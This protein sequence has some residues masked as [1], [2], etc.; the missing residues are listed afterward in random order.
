MKKVKIGWLA[1]LFF[2][3]FLEKTTGQFFGDTNIADTAPI[4]LCNCTVGST[5][6]NQGFGGSSLAVAPNG[7]TYSTIDSD[8][9]YHDFATGQNVFV[10]TMPAE[11]VGLVYGADGL[12]YATISTA[13]PGVPDQL[14][15]INPATG[16]VTIL[17]N[18]PLPWSMVGDIFFYGGQLYGW[19]YDFPNGAV[20]FLVEINVTNPLASTIV[21]STT[22]WGALIAASTVILNGVETVLVNAININTF[23]EGIYIFD[24]NTGEFTVLC[25]NLTMGDS[26]ASP[27]YVVPSCCAND[28]G[29]FQ[30]LNLVQTCGTQNITLTH[31]GDEIL[32]P[33]AA[34]SF[35]LTADS[36]ADLPS[37]IIQISASPTF[38]FDPATMDFGTTYFVAAV[39]APGTAGNPDWLSDCI[40]LSFWAKVRWNELPTVSF[41]LQNPALCP[42]GC[43]EFL[44][45]FTGTPPFGL[46]YENPFTGALQNQV[47]LNP[48]GDIL[49]CSPIATS[50]GTYVL[51]AVSLS[52][53]NCVCN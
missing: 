25:P 45:D 18:M 16:V 42:G 12:L 10:T 33:D 48:T 27:G 19:F 5:V 39:A 52:D 14:I 23:E 47:F 7:N 30:N 35:I 37:E 13:T 4:D 43:I 46:G 50:L 2:F 15:T 49:L 24:M 36:T 26:G 29:N 3:A 40:D 22:E 38:N 21:Y 51:Q 53:A 6:P 17:G 31:L 32:N 20:T 9:Y 41:S 28:A 1:V 11:P 34:L 8:V 44:V